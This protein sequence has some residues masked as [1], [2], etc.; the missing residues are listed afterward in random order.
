M[1]ENL[2]NNQKQMNK[3]EKQEL[4]EK[5]K[6]RKAKIAVIAL[7]TIVVLFVGLQVYASTNGYGNVFF[8][9]KNLITTGNPAGIQEIFSDKDI[10]LSYKSI[11]LAEGLKI[12]ANRLEIR[13]KETK[14]YLLVKGQNAENLPLK[15]EV[16]TKS[17]E[18]NETTTITKITGRKPENAESFEYE[19]VLTLNYVVDENKTIVL[20]ISN[21]SDKELRTLEINLQTR[22]ITVK[23]E[24]EFKKISEIELK[25]YL[26]LFSELNNGSNK[27]DVLLYIAENFQDNYKEFMKEEDYQYRMDKSTDRAYKNAIIKEFYGDKAPKRCKFAKSRSIKR[28]YSLAI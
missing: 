10:T 11:E 22:E 2:N 25:K 1:E 15:Y 8:M 19:E 18:E 21:S 14:L 6:R 16:S 7:S 4:S 26:H 24:K 9:I 13:E 28:N 3:N 23:G 12:Q 5:T 20:K 27:S 17:N